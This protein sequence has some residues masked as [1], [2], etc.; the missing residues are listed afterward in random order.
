MVPA[1]YRAHDAIARKMEQK[2]RLVLVN[3]TGNWGASFTAEKFGIPV[4]NIAL[5]PCAIRTAGHPIIAESLLLVNQFRRDIGLQATD[6][7]D[8]IWEPATQTI[9]M[10]PAWFGKPQSEWSQAGMCVGFPFLDEEG[11]EA[12]TADIGAFICALGKPV[13]F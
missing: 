9:S 8:G 7:I 5:Q 11:S 3:R 6:A 10:F 2:T 1:Y 12:L 4:I 13:V